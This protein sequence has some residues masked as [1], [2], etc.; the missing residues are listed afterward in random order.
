MSYC[1]SNFNPCHMNKKTML[2]RIKRLLFSLAFLSFL[3]Y[4]SARAEIKNAEAKK[5]QNTQTPPKVP[6]K[7]LIPKEI[8]EEKIKSLFPNRKG[9]SFQYAIDSHGRDSLTSIC[10]GYECIYILNNEGTSE[11]VSF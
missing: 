8:K 1:V 11:C 9:F 6:K 4:V 2:S 5:Q 3:L 10:I 7:N